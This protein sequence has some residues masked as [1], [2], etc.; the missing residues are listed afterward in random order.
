MITFLV[1][2]AIVMLVLGLVS[3]LS[4]KRSRP[5]ERS[6]V[7]AFALAGRHQVRVSRRQVPLLLSDHHLDRDQHH[8]NSGSLFFAVAANEPTCSWR[9]SEEYERCLIFTR[10]SRMLRMAKP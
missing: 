9:I 8:P 5:R 10:F 2:T 6:G 7:C 4:S 3:Y 1:T